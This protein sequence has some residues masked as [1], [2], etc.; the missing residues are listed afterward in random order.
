MSTS[1]QPDPESTVP[2]GPDDAT[3]A[4]AENGVATDL[5]PGIDDVDQAGPP[6]RVISGRR[7]RWAVVL[8]LILLLGAAVALVAVFLFLFRPD[9]RTDAAAQQQAIAAAREGTEAVLSYSSENLDKSLADAKS[10]L[11]GEFLD[12][13]SCLLYTSPSPRD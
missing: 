2:E 5:E 6:P 10:H 1:E 13:Y 12:H 8:P 11:T 4:D 9:Q 7:W 3:T